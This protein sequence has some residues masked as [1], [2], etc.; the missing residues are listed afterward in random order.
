ME[1]NEVDEVLNMVYDSVKITAKKIKTN[2]TI[3]CQWQYIIHVF[4]KTLVFSAL[5]L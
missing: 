2:S 4:N 1:N 5:T 3:S